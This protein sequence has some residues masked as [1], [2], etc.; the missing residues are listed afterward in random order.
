MASTIYNA[1]K[2][3]DWKGHKDVFLAQLVR[4]V[5]E[6]INSDKVTIKHDVFHSDNAKRKILMI[7]NM[8]KIIQHIWMEIRA[9]NT[10]KLAA[11][12]DK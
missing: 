9:E 8:N 7:L 4:L 5:G 11:V 10:E 3:S 1:E 6:F 2:R 12:F